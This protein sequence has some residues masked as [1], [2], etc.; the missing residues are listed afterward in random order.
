MEHGLQPAHAELFARVRPD[1]PRLVDW[2]NARFH[3]R[4]YEDPYSPLCLIAG[5]NGDMD[6]IHAYL[7]EYCQSRAR[8]WP[9]SATMSMPASATRTSTKA[10]RWPS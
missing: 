7:E 3:A 8:G 6:R 4:I 2:I 5:N 10:P 9:W 1:L